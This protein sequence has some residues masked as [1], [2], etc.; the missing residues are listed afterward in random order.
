[1][2]RINAR[3]A[4][5]LVTSVALFATSSA[6]ASPGVSVTT[7]PA[8]GHAILTDDNGMTLYRYTQDQG[9]TSVCYDACAAAWPPVLV[10]ALP[11]VQDANWRRIWGSRNATMAASN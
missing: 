4:A 10:D 1:M 9:S 7:S 2:L 5:L 11:A 8:V 6:Y 3:R